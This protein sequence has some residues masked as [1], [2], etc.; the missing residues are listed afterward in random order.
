MG[1]VM[2]LDVGDRRIGVAVS[3]PTCTI[4][5]PLTVLRRRDLGADV[6]AILE[7]AQ[8]QDA[9]E[10]VVGL[11]LGLRGTAGAQAEA[12]RAFG[13]EL[14]RITGMPVQYQDERLTTVA[15][16][17]A[18]VESGMRREQRRERIDAVAAALLLQS[19]LD[20]RKRGGP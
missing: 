6:R 17:R 10:L 1:R 7:L 20:R 9:A 12:V 4:A 5:T 11:P 3:D 13:V 8:S 18:L 19:Y 16:E 15:A 2:G 14:A